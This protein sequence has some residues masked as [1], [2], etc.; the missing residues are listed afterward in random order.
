MNAAQR[1]ILAD[2]LKWLKRR[3]HAVGCRKGRGERVIKPVQHRR[4]G[5]EVGVQAQPM[6]R[7]IA[8]TQSLDSRAEQVHV[9]ISEAIDRL[10]G[11]AHHE[12]RPL[13]GAG[14]AGSQ[15]FEQRV[16]NA[17][18]ILEFVDQ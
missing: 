9:G 8:E 14:P 10:H 16:L 3:Q 6:Q 18:G 5:A 17:R 7:D 2:R 12:Q 15:A 13:V 4:A 11:I 1:R